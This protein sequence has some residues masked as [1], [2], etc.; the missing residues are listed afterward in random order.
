MISIK[1]HKWHI[2]LAF[3]FCSISLIFVWDD[4]W[5]FYLVPLGLIGLYCILFYTEFTF[6]SLFFLTPLSFN[7]E[8]FTQSFGL[9]IPTE[10]ILAC[11]MLLVLA[12][13]LKQSIIP[14]FIWKNELIWVI[15][16]YLGWILLT[17]ITSSN[18]LVSF[19]FLL[20]KLWFIIPIFSI[21]TMVFQK[22][23][24]IYAFLWLFVSGMMVAMIYTLIHHAG[25]QFGEKEG[26]WVMSPLFKD[27]T[28]YGAMV[29]FTIPLIFGLY[30]AKK[31]GPL[32]QAILISFFAI[33]LIALYFSYTR[34]A[35]LSIIVALGVWL[36][37][38]LRIKFSILL[39][40]SIALGLLVFFSWTSIEQNLAKNKSEHTT[41]DFGKRLESVSNVTTDAS[42]LERLNRWSCA[43]D[44][45]RDR[46][47]FGYGPG[48][49]AFEYARFQR[50]ENL[51][52]ISTN[53]GDGG[54]AHSEYLGPLAEMGFVGF[55][56]VLALVSAIFY[57]G[58]TTYYRLFSDNKEMRILVLA[59]ILSL[60]TYFF[61]G[62]L[63]NYLDTDKAAVPVWSICAVFLVLRKQVKQTNF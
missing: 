34:A 44:M 2:L 41:E 45:F 8:E 3:L 17:S 22:H 47:V 9:F 62:I 56:L 26:H 13:E 33:N 35:W 39:S 59:M 30:F 12:V 20:A 38:K 36:L 60:V 53:F 37:I 6:L 50:P 10:P 57:L 54:N 16:G 21:G 27:H 5:F 63:N 18:P 40:V 28:I 11:L 55:L 61:H 51:T 1:E 23:S 14:K 42:N 15:I 4:N 43:L 58:V 29:A 19:K 24:R 48:T 52:I 32:V 46:P 31:N 7:I 25:Y 49:Y